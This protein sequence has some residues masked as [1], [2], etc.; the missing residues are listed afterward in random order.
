MTTVSAGEM[1]RCYMWQNILLS[2]NILRW[3]D[4]RLKTHTAIVIELLLEVSSI[5]FHYPECHTV[6]LI[7][8]NVCTVNGQHGSCVHCQH[9]SLLFLAITKRIINLTIIGVRCQS[10]FVNTLRNDI[11]RN[12]TSSFY[13]ELNWYARAYLLVTAFKSYQMKPP[14]H[15]YL[16]IRQ[17]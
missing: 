11:N 4:I 2:E 8:N 5:K 13:H 14:C 9:R 17:C 1:R 12:Y 16:V 10:I 7:L 15:F 3:W 6:F